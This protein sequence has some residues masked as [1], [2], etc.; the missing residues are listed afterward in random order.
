MVIMNAERF[1][2]S[3]L[4]QLRGRVGRG[5]YQAH[6][7]LVADPKSIESRQRIKAMLNTTNGFELA[8]E[9]LKIRGPGNLLGTQQSGEIVFAFANLSNKP[10]IQRVVAC[11]DAVLKFPETY[12]DL[13]EY[14]SLQSSVQAELLN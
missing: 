7:F 6:C 10:L 13:N 11:C 9:D 2:L 3:Q 1:G 14:F 8:E 4:H 12:Y 5:K